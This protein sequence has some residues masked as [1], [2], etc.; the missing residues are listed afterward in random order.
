MEKKEFPLCKTGKKIPWSTAEKAYEGYVK[1]YGRVQ[2]LERI[3]ERGGFYVE[4]MDLFYAGWREEVEE[5]YLLRAEVETLRSLVPHPG[6]GSC[7][8]CGTAPAAVITLC[9]ECRTTSKGCDEC[10]GDGWVHNRVEG[11]AA[12]TCMIEAE[13]FQI[14]LKALERIAQDKVGYGHLGAG[15]PT[16]V[17][18]IAQKALK[19]VLP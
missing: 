5:I 3:E 13:P 7:E 16:A 14:L 6:D 10:N 11:R 4:E 15:S 9:E 2:T 19:S 8:F 18:V 12:C 1:R 17:A